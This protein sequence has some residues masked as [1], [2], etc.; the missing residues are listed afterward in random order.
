MNKHYLI[1]F[2]LFICPYKSFGASFVCEITNWGNNNSSLSSWLPGTFTLN[3]DEKTITANIVKRDNVFD[4]N[5]TVY[6][7]TRLEMWFMLDGAILSTGQKSV[8]HKFSFT[9]LPLINKLIFIRHTS[10]YLPSSPAN[11]KCKK[12]EITKTST[13]NQPTLNTNSTKIEVAKKEC[14]DIGYKK[15]TEKY[16]DCVMKL[17]ED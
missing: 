14:S 8:P 12:V 6:T 10:G 17:I 2:F 11:G 9:Y 1:I 3:P 7:P 13:I 5:L 15:G 4:A 16:A